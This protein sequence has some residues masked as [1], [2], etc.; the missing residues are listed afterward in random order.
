M[1]DLIFA[2]IVFAAIIAILTDTY[3]EA[4]LAATVLL[5][6][7]QITEMFGPNLFFAIF[8]I[9]IAAIL[10]IAAMATE[11]VFGADD[12]RNQSV[13]SFL[14][15]FL[16]ANDGRTEQ[17]PQNHRLP[18]NQATERLDTDVESIEDYHR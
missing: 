4:V 15:E 13:I 2:L 11:N 14:D 1:D 8:L 6:I 18:D 16:T 17:D 5:I 7:W 12:T 3:G 9:M 10:K